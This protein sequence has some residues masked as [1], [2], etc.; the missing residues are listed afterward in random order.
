MFLIES[1][2]FDLQFA[3]LFHSSKNLDYSITQALHTIRYDTILYLTWILRLANYIPKFKIPK[4]QKKK[5]QQQQQIILQQY[6]I[7][8]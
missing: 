3:K 4:Q 6:K 8:N 2:T 1:E 7:T 5:Q